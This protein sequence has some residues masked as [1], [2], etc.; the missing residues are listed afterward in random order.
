MSWRTVRLLGPEF[1][2]AQ[3]AVDGSASPA[4]PSP[5][6]ESGALQ[7]FGATGQRATLAASAGMDPI[8][9]TS[10]NEQAGSRSKT[11]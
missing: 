6:A 1:M 4:S 8:V 2:T 7:V 3:Q 5:D 11:A 9:C 10:Q